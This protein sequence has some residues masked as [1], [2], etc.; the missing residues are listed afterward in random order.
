MLK[1]TAL[2]HYYTNFNP[3]KP[4]QLNTLC[5]I[6]KSKHQQSMLVKWNETT[7][8][9]ILRNNESMDVE[10][11]LNTL[12]SEIRH[13]KM[14]LSPEFRANKIFFAKLLQACRMHPA[15]SI[16][17]ST[18]TDDSVSSLINLLRSNVATWKAQQNSSSDQNPHS[19]H[20]NAN[21]YLTDRRYHGG[22]SNRNR[23]DNYRNRNNNQKNDYKRKICFVCRKEG[24]W[25]T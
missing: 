16:V 20:Q 21:I 23:R 22:N 3:D 2:Q 19:N 6:I 12:I 7:L 9:T 24:F 25:S 15:C 18:I 11:A 10:I 13:I 17:C 14:S 4:P 8:N 1:N 5:Q